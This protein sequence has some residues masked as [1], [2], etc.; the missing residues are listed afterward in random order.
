MSQ[1]Q[2]SQQNFSLLA[3]V[4]EV[5]FT[6][7]A[8]GIHGQGLG[9]LAAAVAS[10]D[11]QNDVDTENGKT[12]S[13]PLE[14]IERGADGYAADAVRAVSQKCSYLR[15]FAVT[16]DNATQRVSVWYETLRALQR[17]ALGGRKRA[18]IS[19]EALEAIERQMEAVNLGRTVKVKLQARWWSPEQEPEMYPCKTGGF[20]RIVTVAT[21]YFDTEY[22]TIDSV[23]EWIKTNYGKT[24][25]GW[26]RGT[27]QS[28]VYFD[29]TGKTV[30]TKVTP[31]SGVFFRTVDGKQQQQ[32]VL[33]ARQKTD[34]QKVNLAR[35]KQLRLDQL[36]KKP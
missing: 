35:I 30:R 19:P 8:P 17:S 34:E 16:A 36:G 11:R 15:D 7:K 4:Q 22:E 21:F 29:D 24:I 28:A 18:R 27:A 1:S 23:V 2:A 14:T 13:I 31:G 3:I 32:S 26:K 9:V 20:A 33:A 12:V 25:D 10:S 6:Y 5:G